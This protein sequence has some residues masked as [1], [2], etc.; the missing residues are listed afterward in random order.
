V[1]RMNANFL[2]DTLSKAVVEM[3]ELMREP[4]LNQGTAMWESRARCGIVKGEMF[5]EA[6]LTTYVLSDMG[7]DSE[8]SRSAPLAEFELPV[9]L[10]HD[11]QKPQAIRAGRFGE[12]EVKQGK[13]ECPIP[14]S[15]VSLIWAL[16]KS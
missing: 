14:R 4:E 12:R 1:V 9:S 10:R 13:R 6:G 11:L 7:L 15:R 5:R 2:P 3:S 8:R 16:G